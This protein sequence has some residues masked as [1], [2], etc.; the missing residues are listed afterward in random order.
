MREI[1]DKGQLDGIINKVYG[2]LKKVL[3]LVVDGKGSNELVETKR[4]KQHV[5]SDLPP[6]EI[7]ADEETNSDQDNSALIPLPTVL[8]FSNN[9]DQEEDDDC[10]LI[11]CEFEFEQQN[12][13]NVMV[14]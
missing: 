7:A 8:D 11:V 6:V 1:W 9:L 10:G 12:G 3:V 2:R 14:P 5:R 4:G 13:Q